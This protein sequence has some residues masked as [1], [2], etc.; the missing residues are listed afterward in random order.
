MPRPQPPEISQ[1]SLT[2]RS[3]AR[4]G[5]ASAD[6]KTHIK[7]TLIPPLPVT[8]ADDSI[9]FKTAVKFN[10]PVNP[11]RPCHGERRRPAAACPAFGWTRGLAGR[12]ERG[13]EEKGS[14][15]ALRTLCRS[16]RWKYGMETSS[17]LG[18]PAVCR[19]R[20]RREP[21]SPPRSRRR[22]EEAAQPVQSP[23]ICFCFPA[24]ASVPGSAKPLKSAGICSPPPIT[25]CQRPPL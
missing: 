7:Y 1:G 20:E 22:G 11:A 9:N 15:R 2:P 12:R 8:H 24:C 23:P 21:S 13:R 19:V 17:A 5:A 4:A 10:F 6:L 18:S 3:S 16:R 25:S 14:T